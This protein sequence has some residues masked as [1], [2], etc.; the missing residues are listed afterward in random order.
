[1]VIRVKDVGKLPHS[2]ITTYG[3]THWHRGKQRGKE[4]DSRGKKAFQKGAGTQVMLRKYETGVQSRGMMN[5][6]ARSVLTTQELSTFSYYVE[7]Y[8]GRG[9]SVDDLST[10]LLELLDTPEKVYMCTLNFSHAP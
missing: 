10:A 1:M 8:D 3:E 5:E 7:Q 6:V 2:R 4:K 9:L